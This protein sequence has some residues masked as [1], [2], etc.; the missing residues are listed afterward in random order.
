M[1]EP[2]AL[3]LEAIPESELTNEAIDAC[4]PPAK[5]PTA[6]EDYSPVCSECDCKFER[7]VK[8]GPDECDGEYGVGD[9]QEVWLCETCL[10]AALAL[11]QKPVA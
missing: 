7:V 1:K 4:Y 3:K 6:P 2:V 11:I 9:V 8:V 10:T 5:Y